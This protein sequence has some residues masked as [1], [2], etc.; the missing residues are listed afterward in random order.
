MKFIIE[1]KVF[2]TFYNDTTC[3]DQNTNGKKEVTLVTCNN[4]NGNRIIVKAREI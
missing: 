4:S 1:D 3:T 2:E